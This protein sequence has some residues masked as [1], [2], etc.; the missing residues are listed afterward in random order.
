VVEMFVER[1]VGRFVET[2]EVGMFEQSIVQLVS[3]DHFDNSIAMTGS[4]Q[5]RKMRIQSGRELVVL[6]R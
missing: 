5:I 3:I 1:F 6:D 4:K 2:W